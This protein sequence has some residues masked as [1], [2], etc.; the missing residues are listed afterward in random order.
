MEPCAHTITLNAVRQAV[1]Q[2][3]LTPRG[4]HAIQHLLRWLTDDG[5]SLDETNQEAVITLL[6]G[7]WGSFPKSAMGWLREYA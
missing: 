5:L 7:A 3:A 2:L 1:E 4:V 6:Q